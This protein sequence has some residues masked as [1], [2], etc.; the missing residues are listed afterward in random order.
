MCT[1]EDNTL[2]LT[3]ESEIDSKELLF[4][5]SLS[6]F[7]ARSWTSLLRNHKVVPQSLCHH[8]Q[9]M[10]QSFQ[11]RLRLDV[12]R[13]HDE[14]WWNFSWSKGAQGHDGSHRLS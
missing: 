2:T 11:N 9:G 14:H 13:F 12:G 5:L 6:A 3:E 4:Q 7:P 1:L 8:Q 10:G